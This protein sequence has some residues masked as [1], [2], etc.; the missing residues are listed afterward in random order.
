MKIAGEII[1][2]DDERYEEEFL[3]EVL[4]ALNYEIK[5]IYFDHAMDALDY[6]R[7]THKEIFLIISD[8]HMGDISGIKLKEIL[9]SD[10]TT[11]LKSIPFVLMSNH[12][13]KQNINEAYRHNIQGFFKKPV[14]LRNLT[15][16]FSM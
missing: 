13:T 12:A 9:N 8:I 6:I 1:L 3:K 2:V 5:V 14:G 16:L 15:E 4:I 7:K 11:V 10:P